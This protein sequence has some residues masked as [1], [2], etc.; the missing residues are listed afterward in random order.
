LL[1]LDACLTIWSSWLGT[2]FS[3]VGDRSGDVL[4]L[5]LWTLYVCVGRGHLLST[6]PMYMVTPLLVC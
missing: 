4:D 3:G 1:L 5:F 2:D 6:V